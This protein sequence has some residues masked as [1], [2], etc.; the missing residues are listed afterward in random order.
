MEA[1]E[2]IARDTALTLSFDCEGREVW[3]TRRPLAKAPISEGM[4]TILKFDEGGMS[5]DDLIIQ[6]LKFNPGTEIQICE[7]NGKFPYLILHTNGRE[8]EEFIL[9]KG[10]S[11]SKVAI[12][13]RWEEECTEICLMEVLHRRN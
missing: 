8:V 9:P 4:R 12:W 3:S 6:I 10:V 2:Q 5:S 1:L 13:Y 7:R 11:I